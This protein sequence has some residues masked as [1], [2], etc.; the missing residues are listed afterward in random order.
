MPTRQQP[1]GEVVELDTKPVLDERARGHES[2]AAEEE[3]CRVA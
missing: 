1:A 2:A 3:Q